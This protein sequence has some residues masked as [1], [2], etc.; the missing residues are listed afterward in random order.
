MVVDIE[1]ILV[2]SVI[3]AIFS[4]IVGVLIA[5]WVKFTMKPAYEKNF[6]ENRKS[7]T[8]WLF[9]NL[10]RYHK[11]AMQIFD[12]FEKEFGELEK[13]RK[14]L[15]TE[16]EF[17][18]ED[19]LEKTPPVSFKNIIKDQKKMEYLKERLEWD[20][21]YMKKYA[22]EYEKKDNV[23][24]LRDYFNFDDFVLKIFSLIKNIND[25]AGGLFQTDLRPHSLMWAIKNSESVVKYL[26]DNKLDKDDENVKA[27]IDRW[28]DAIK[29]YL[30]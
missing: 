10:E 20:L 22:L 2:S 14:K 28:E 30:K 4:A 25:Y 8:K 16:M 13:I 18:P 21:E 29:K 3:A 26:K 24:T 9:N 11:S 1:T 27:F 6:E 17:V 12:N 5:L 23:N 7:E 15:V 19:Q